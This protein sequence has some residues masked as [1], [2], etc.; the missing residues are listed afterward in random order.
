MVLGNP[1][2]R[3]VQP[4]QEV[5]TH[6][7]RTAY[8]EPPQFTAYMNLG[9]FAV[10]ACWVCPLAMLGPFLGL[11]V[12]SRVRYQ[13]QA[14]HRAKRLVTEG[15]RPCYTKDHMSRSRGG[16]NYP[17]AGKLVQGPG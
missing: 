12:R 14:G 7:F 13:I 3:V 16:R 4:A 10:D 6:R 15:G 1:R 17:W 9:I 5:A 8:L 11:Q 2:E